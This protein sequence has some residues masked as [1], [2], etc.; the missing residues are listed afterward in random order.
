[1]KNEVKEMLTTEEIESI[2]QED[3]TSDKKKFARKGQKYYDGAHDIK[4]Y[5]LF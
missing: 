3:R 1:M 5:R 2:M 4:K